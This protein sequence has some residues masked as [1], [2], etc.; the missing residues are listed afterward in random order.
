M[1]DSF[2]LVG[3]MFFAGRRTL[4]SPGNFQLPQGQL[5][6]LVLILQK[7]PQIVSD[8]KCLD[9]KF[10]SF[11]DVIS[12]FPPQESIVTLWLAMDAKCLSLPAFSEQA[13]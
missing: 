8:L 4:D 7:V 6:E 2:F 12:A 9:V 10:S 3:R 5:W 11:K 1:G 13:A